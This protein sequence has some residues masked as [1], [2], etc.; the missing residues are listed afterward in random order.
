MRT[1]RASRVYPVLLLALA[2]VLVIFFF[3]DFHA[4][5][6][7]RAVAAAVF[8]ASVVLQAVLLL[9]QTELVLDET[10]F[11]YRKRR[12]FGGARLE[13]I[14]CENIERIRIKG[15]FVRLKLVDHSVAMLK[16][17]ILSRSDRTEVLDWFRR[18]PQH[19]DDPYGSPG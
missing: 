15:A 16:L 11:S 13:T 8:V 19:V 6:I 17:T 7:S 3:A 2:A 14:S 9:V 10:G 1:Y 4:D 5:R 12:W 18:L